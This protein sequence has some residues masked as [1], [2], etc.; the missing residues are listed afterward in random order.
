MSSKKTVGWLGLV[1]ILAALFFFTRR[2]SPWIPGTPRPAPASGIGDVDMDGFV[3]QSD[4]TA[5]QRIVMGI[6]VPT[7]EQLRRADANGDGEVNIGDVIAIE[8][9]YTGLVDT[10]P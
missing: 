1:A 4:A 6:L 2:P 8:R 9:Y 5:V 3:G 7:A 10:L